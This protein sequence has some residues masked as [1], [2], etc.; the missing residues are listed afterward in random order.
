MN[1]INLS[2][3]TLA[4]SVV[5][6]ATAAPPAL[7]QGVPYPY[8]RLHLNPTQAERIQDLDQDWK[9]RYS[10]LSPRLQHEQRRL[11]DLL[12]TPK[13]DPL[14][15]TTSQQR[16]NQIREQ[17]NQQATTNYLRKRRLLNNDQQQQLQG[18]LRRMV[19]ERGGRR[20]N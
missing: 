3:T 9:S 16:I 4:L 18:H 14:E 1:R 2:I 12:A 20:G 13:S 11:R 10:E 15:I 5:A 6:L 19:A 7:A 8:D 17:L